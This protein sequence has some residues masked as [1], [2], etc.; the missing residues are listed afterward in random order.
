MKSKEL[1]TRILPPSLLRYSDGH[2]YIGQWRGGERWGFGRMEET[3]R[4]NSLYT[5]GWEADRRCGYGVY[6]DKM[7]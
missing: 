1:G 3:S 5:G 6:E 7:R 4:R 2:I